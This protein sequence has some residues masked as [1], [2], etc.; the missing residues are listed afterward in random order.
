MLGVAI[1]LEP[2]WVPWL[3]YDRWDGNR[4]GVESKICPLAGLWTKCME[5]SK[6]VCVAENDWVI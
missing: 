3:E 5:R 6:E 4:G 2:G 1:N